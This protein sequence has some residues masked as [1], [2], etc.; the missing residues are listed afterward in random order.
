V[1]ADVESGDRMNAVTA[2]EPE[3]KDLLSAARLGGDPATMIAPAPRHARHELTPAIMG[4][5]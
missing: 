3:A 4:V 5:G 1:A 2:K